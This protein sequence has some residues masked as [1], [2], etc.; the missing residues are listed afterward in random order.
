MGLQEVGA[1][2]GGEHSKACAAVRATKGDHTYDAATDGYTGKPRQTGT[3]LAWPSA[4]QPA[5]KPK[6]D[7]HGDTLS[8]GRA[9]S[10]RLS[11]AGFPKTLVVAIY[12][13]QHDDAAAV[14][15]TQAWIQAKTDPYID[16]EWEV[17]LLSDTNSTIDA[18]DRISGSKPNAQDIAPT[19]LGWV[20]RLLRI[21]TPTNAPDK[22][23][24][25]CLGN[26]A[27]VCGLERVTGGGVRLY[28]CLRNRFRAER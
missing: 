24:R 25:G 13:P 21:R 8:G 4:W 7:K 20:E 18:C 6:F 28:F 3:L 10:Y 23:V 2:A 27:R 14:A 9:T 17:V 12:A 11:I 5:G 15:T 26:E 16:A 1:R 19:P 22:I